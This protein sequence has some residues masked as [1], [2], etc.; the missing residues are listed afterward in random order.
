MTFLPTDWQA[1]AIYGAVANS[2]KFKKPHIS[3]ESLICSA[4]VNVDNNVHR[5]K[6]CLGSRI[7][8]MWIAN[9]L[10]Q[11]LNVNVDDPEEQLVKNL[12]KKRKL[13]CGL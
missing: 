13:V 11:R 1:T 10:W 2:F 8:W 3:N 9:K 6:L 4:C 5:L 12:K 7:I